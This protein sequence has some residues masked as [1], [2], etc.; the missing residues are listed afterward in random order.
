MERQ[1]EM[2]EIKDAYL[3]D[4]TSVVSLLPFLLTG[5]SERSCEKE[6]HLLTP[7]ASSA[8]APPSGSAS[9]HLNTLQ[10]H[11]TLLAKRESALL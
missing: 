2:I 1:D 5:G 4:R 8:V 3:N 9:L 7:L 11:S 6:Q 10:S